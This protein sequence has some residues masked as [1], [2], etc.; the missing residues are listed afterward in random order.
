MRE[1]L[2][3]NLGYRTDL[4]RHLLIRQRRGQNS[5]DKDNGEDKKEGGDEGRKEMR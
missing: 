5:T 4:L 1:G 3:R 2:T